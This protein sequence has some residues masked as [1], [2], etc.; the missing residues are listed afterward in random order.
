MVSLEF[1]CPSNS[2]HR[3]PRWLCLFIELFERLATLSF[4]GSKSICASAV[5]ND[6]RRRWTGKLRILGED[7]EAI[8]VDKRAIG[9]ELF[10]LGYNIGIAFSGWAFLQYGGGTLEYD[11]TIHCTLAPRHGALDA[12][13]EYAAGLSF[14]GVL[15]DRGNNV[16]AENWEELP[17]A[18]QKH[19]H[20]L[21]V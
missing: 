10:S 7:Q 12:A 19:L 5:N 9:D 8:L 4:P 2:P 11:E 13:K 1:L 21:A 15:S 3:I 16:G 17:N 20:I 18:C 6:R 14:R